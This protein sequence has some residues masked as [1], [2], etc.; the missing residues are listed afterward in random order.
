MFEEPANLDPV[1]G[2]LIALV[3]ER[4]VSLAAAS[5][6]IGRNHSYL[7]QFVKRG[8]PRRLPEETRHDLASFLNVD[9]RTL[10]PPDDRTAVAG[11]ADRR[12]LSSFVARLAVARAE[13]RFATPSAFAA[14]AGID[15]WRYGELEDG[16]EQPALD[17]LDRIARTSGKRLDWLIRGGAD[18]RRPAVHPDMPIGEF[19]RQGRADRPA[20]P[21]P[22]KAVDD[23]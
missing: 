9:E 4:D 18:H 12:E 14:A 15:R 6:A 5:R 19:G 13:S 2:R 21:R 22:G 20:T 8:T 7:Q 17:E 1:R 3:A 23:G 10:R 16:E 11:A